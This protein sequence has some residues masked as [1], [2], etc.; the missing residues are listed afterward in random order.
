VAGGETVVGG[1]AVGRESAGASGGDD[2]SRLLHVLERSKE[3]GLLGPGPVQSHLH[4]ARTFLPFLPASGPLLDLGSGG[5]VPG[6]V[7][8]VLRPD[9]SVALLDGAARRCSFLHWAVEELAVSERMTV[10]HGRAE[11]MARRPDLRGRFTA[12]T[13]RSFG[14][15][16]T[17]AEC[18]IG[19]LAPGG[20]V[21]VS[22]PPIEDPV[23]RWPDVGL[24]TMGLRRGRRGT[25][26]GVVGTVQE[27]VLDH[28]VA[29]RWP[30]RDGVPGRR[31]IF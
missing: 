24:A 17:T 15:P 27:L 30:R 20:S 11:L 6:L 4:H 29:E 19:F 25:T 12:V 16:A 8:G 2:R 21:L 26:A 1:A 18:A 14:R 13:A 31:P 10:V 22:E 28:P 3:L 23:I 7:L 5:G 9:L